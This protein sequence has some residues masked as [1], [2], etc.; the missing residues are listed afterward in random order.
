MQISIVGDDAISMP[1][2]VVGKRV[3]SFGTPIVAE[4]LAQSGALITHIDLN[5]L[6]P[7]KDTSFDIAIYIDQWGSDGQPLATLS[8]INRAL[9]RGG[10]LLARGKCFTNPSFHS[11]PISVFDPKDGT[12]LPNATCVL[13]WL[14]ASGFDILHDREVE[15]VLTVTASPTRMFREGI[16]AG[17]ALPA[18]TN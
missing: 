18:R 6:R 17:D 2:D 14:A 4:T 8:Y 7:V 9:V 16:V 15:D 12:Q 1:N 13:G 5:D 10:L 11:A 3:L